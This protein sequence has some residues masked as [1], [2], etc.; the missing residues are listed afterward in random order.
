MPRTAK[1][2]PRHQSS[3]SHLEPTP[4][5]LDSPL[6][7]SREI[8]TSRREHGRVWEIIRGACQTMGDPEL[9]LNTHAHPTGCRCCNGKPIHRRSREPPRIS[10]SLTCSPERVGPT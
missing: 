2:P 7:I 10:H 9:D 4:V 8:T 3:G 5:R 1:V 6:R